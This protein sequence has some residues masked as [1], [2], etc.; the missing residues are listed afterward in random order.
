MIKIEKV[1]SLTCNN[2]GSCYVIM[3]E[4]GAECDDCKRITAQTSDL[5]ISQNNK[6]KL[7]LNNFGEINET[8]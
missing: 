3:T 6:L 4:K 5:L 1:P 7:T 8:I 2:C